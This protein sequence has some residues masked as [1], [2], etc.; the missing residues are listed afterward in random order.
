MYLDQNLGLRLS[1]SKITLLF[2]LRLY[3][4]RTLAQRKAESKVK[5]THYAVF[6]R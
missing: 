3:L 4:D 5:G 1:L 6:A 2:D